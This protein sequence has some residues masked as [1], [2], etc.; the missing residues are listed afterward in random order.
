MAGPV[1]LAAYDIAR[2]CQVEF[3]PAK[4]HPDWAAKINALGMVIFESAEFSRLRPQAQRRYRT[5]L[6]EFVFQV[7][8][9]CVP[10]MRYIELVQAHRSRPTATSTRKLCAEFRELLNRAA[11]LEAH[12]EGYQPR[13]S[14]MGR[15]QPVPLS[16][17]LARERRRMIKELKS[18]AA[19]K[20]T[21]LVSGR[22][23]R[24]LL[25]LR[26]FAA[27]RERLRRYPK[28]MRNLMEERL[29]VR[30]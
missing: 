28:H 2:L 25:Q 30:R 6:E 29:S 1:F 4:K 18:L 22:E 13:P 19:L 17:R 11:S 16:A 8:G 7:G 9:S 20:A 24:E 26:A 3:T 23:S 27:E 15:V 12:T 14:G 10:T 5:W 21:P